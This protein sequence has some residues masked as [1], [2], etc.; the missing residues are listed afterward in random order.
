[1]GIAKV[2]RNYQVTIP[3]DIRRLEDIRIGD[4][5]LFA[6]EGNRIDFLKLE[7][8][9]M[10]KSLAGAWKDKINVS[11]AEYVREFRKEW[12]KRSKRLGL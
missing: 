10:L 11:G 8:K 12:G 7:R 5:V 6:I 4:T 3:R 9:K 1:M 2:T